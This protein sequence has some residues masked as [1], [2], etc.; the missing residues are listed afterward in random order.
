MDVKQAFTIP[1]LD[2]N[3][4]VYMELPLG[5]FDKETRQAY[6]YRLNKSLYGLRKAAK[7]W[8]DYLTAYL[9]SYGFKRSAADPC[10]L[11]L[12]DKRRT[13]LTFYSTCLLT[14]IAFNCLHIALLFTPFGF[15]LGT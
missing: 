14:V 3:D 12:K 7:Y 2:S 13:N 1:P 5:W 15:D 9:Q 6:V 11:H 4:E 8:A 10:L